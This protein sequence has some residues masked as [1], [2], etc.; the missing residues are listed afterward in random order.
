MLGGPLSAAYRLG[1]SLFGV[2][3]PFPIEVLHYAW[4]ENHS[5]AERDLHMRFAS[6]RLEGE[7]FNLD[8]TDIRYIRGLGETLPAEH[9]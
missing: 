2:K 6:K 8:D 9:G 5:K 4:F 7:W 3:L 1:G